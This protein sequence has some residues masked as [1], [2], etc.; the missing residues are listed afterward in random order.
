M[1]LL[2]D[3]YNFHQKLFELSLHDI[4]TKKY[5]QKDITKKNGGIRTLNIPPN[6]AKI[7]QKKL[8][9]ILY[10]IYVPPEPVHGFIKSQN[11]HT[12]NVVSNATKHINKNVVINIDIDSF[13]DSINFGRVRGLF[14]SKPFNLDA[15]IA[16]KLAQLMTHEN[17]L[18][19]GAP[20]SPIISNFICKK[21]DHSLIQLA[22]KYT[23]TYTRY[24]DDIS[25]SSHKKNINTKKILNEVEKIIKNNGFKVNKSKTRVQYSYQSQIV[26]GLKVNKKVNVNRK[27]IRQIRS[28]L[29]SWYTHGL[30]EAT[31]KHFHTNYE[32]THKSNAS[33][34][35]FGS[36]LLFKIFNPLC[37]FFKI[38]Y[39]SKDVNK[40]LIKYNYQVNKYISKQEQ[41]FKNILLGRINFLGQVRGIDDEI[42]I[43]FKHSYYLLN[44]DFKLKNKIDEFENLDINNLNKKEVL[45]IFSQIYNSILVFTEGETDI[46]YIKSA[47]KHFQNKDKF[48]SLELR[49]CNLNSVS[50]IA[51]IYKALYVKKE[52]D[53][54]ILNVRKCILQY[55]KNNLKICFIPDSDSLNDVKTLTESKIKNYYLMAEEEK[56][57]VE[58]LFDKEMIF[59]I[60][61]EH[62]YN[63]DITNEKLQTSSKK[64]LE[65]YL[66][67]KEYGD[68]SIHSVSS[69]SYI[70]YK[71]MII[72]KPMLAD[73]IVKKDIVNYDRFEEMFKFLDE[74]SYNK[75]YVGKLCCN[76]IY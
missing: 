63:I 68:D 12:K 53:I 74:M 19:Q 10:K 1:Q 42:F 58:N 41:S 54:F 59:E 2:S 34:E 75:E 26:T 37:D 73:L 30:N 60:I 48:K 70:A 56:G 35:Y 38:K 66:K 32:Y 39:C 15:N 14:L 27:Y 67:S 8:S 62:G 25:F 17:K 69:T 72:T 20:T 46:T 5:T 43:K 36:K 23:L 44:D 21:I 50:N 22:K 45:T 16:T 7:L 55:I 33:K 31:K 11:N 18:P 51:N 40:I 13:F 47:L 76:S 65:A 61:R 4:R 9:D 28:M 64:G 24:A 6:S 52:K 71:D 57:Y 3:F 49:F 29:F